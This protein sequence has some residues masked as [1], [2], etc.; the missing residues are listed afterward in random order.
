MPRPQQMH[1][2]PLNLLIEEATDFIRKHEPPEGYFVAFS[3]GKDSI[4]TLELVRMA[5]VKHEV[6]YSA[7]GIDPPEVMRFIRN[8]YADI[9]WLRPKYSF[10]EGIRKKTPPLRV[11]RWCCDVLKKNPSKKVGLKHR[12]LGLR[13]EESFS[14]AQRPKVETPDHVRQTLYKPIFH[15]LEWHVWE[16]IEERGLPYPVLYDEGFH[17]IGCVI[18]PFIDGANLRRHKERWP[19]YYRTFE[20]VVRQW[21]D[22]KR[23]ISPMLQRFNI[24]T[25]DEFLRFWY[26]EI[27]KAP[28]FSECET[29]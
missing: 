7:T 15:W 2:I 4:V 13:R 5:G 26:G 28:V 22:A 24:T 21:F 14:R 10:W 11:S 6:F 19:G 8:H 27:R 20:T 12:I 23:A 16:F 25:S 29:V 17:R 9:Q 3:G 18:C 1:M